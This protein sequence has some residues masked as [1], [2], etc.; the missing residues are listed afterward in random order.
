MPVNDA[1]LET[2]I[3]RAQAEFQIVNDKENKLR[4]IL[5]NFESI[6]KQT[7]KIPNASGGFDIEEKIPVDRGTGKELTVARRDNIFNEN[8]ALLDAVLA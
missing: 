6:K 3:A 2:E 4:N 5:R 7:L 1:E 8:K